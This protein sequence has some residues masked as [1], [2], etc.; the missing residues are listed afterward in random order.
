MRT[1]LMIAFVA[2]N[3]IA[4]IGQTEEVI[5]HTSAECGSCKDRIEGKLNYTSGIRFAELDVPSKDL[6]VKYN[7]KKI[8]IKEIKEILSELGYDADEVKANPKAVE[9]LPACCKPGGMKK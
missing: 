1:L 3:S 8:T 2:I 9:K 6:T 7:P 5:I 4:V